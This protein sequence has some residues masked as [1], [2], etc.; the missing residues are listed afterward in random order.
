MPLLLG[1]SYTVP[2]GNVSVF[3]VHLIR[4]KGDEDFNEQEEQQIPVFASQPKIPLLHVCKTDCPLHDSFHDIAPTTPSPKEPT[5][6]SLN[7]ADMYVH[8]V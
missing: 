5:D 8:V 7:D 4:Q 2:T 1:P 3:R 6:I